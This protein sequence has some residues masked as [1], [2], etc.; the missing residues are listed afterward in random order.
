MKL[1]KLEIERF[2]RDSKDYFKFKNSCDAAVHNS[3]NLTRYIILPNLIKVEAERAIKG[4]VLADENYAMVMKTIDERPGNKQKIINLH[5]DG[6]LST[7]SVTENELRGVRN[8]YNKVTPHLR[9]LKGR[10]RNMWQA[11]DS[12]FN[13]TRVKPDDKSPFDSRAERWNI[14]DVTEVLRKEIE[15]RERLKNTAP[16]KKEVLRSTEYQRPY[17]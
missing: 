16:E 5:M 17:I 9:S 1:P 15:V 14:D 6:L 2:I 11:A 7:R 4:L 8:V 10:L 13:A 3:P 12:N